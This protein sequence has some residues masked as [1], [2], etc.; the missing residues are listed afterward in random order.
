MYSRALPIFIFVILLVLQVE[1][2]G[3]RGRN[4]GEK[5]DIVADDDDI[6]TRRDREG[7]IREY[8]RLQKYY[9]AC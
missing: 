2:R 8:I 5:R 4:N 1:G 9:F 3:N 7:K 6:K